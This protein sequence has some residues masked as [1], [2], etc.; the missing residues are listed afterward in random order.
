M[1]LDGQAGFFCKTGLLMR[2]KGLMRFDKETKISN[3]VSC[4]WMEIHH[5]KKLRNTN[6]GTQKQCLLQENCAF[7]DIGRQEGSSPISVPLSL[8][9]QCIHFLNWPMLGTIELWSR[10]SAS[11]ECSVI[12]TIHLCSN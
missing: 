8:V 10:G 6:T 9:N 5:G 4:A 1:S 7:S 11:L 12:G 3:A 2:V